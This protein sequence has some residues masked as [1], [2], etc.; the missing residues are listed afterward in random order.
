M[1]LEEVTGALPLFFRVDPGLP[2]ASP[3]EDADA[4][5]SLSLPRRYCWSLR[6]VD[7]E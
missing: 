6:G 2:D 4:S 3:A 5:L 1:S 7:F